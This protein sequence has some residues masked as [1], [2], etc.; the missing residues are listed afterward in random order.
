MA[1]MACKPE[2]CL[3]SHA[4]A[5]GFVSESS[6]L[7]INLKCSTFFFFLFPYYAS[8]HSLLKIT[9]MPEM[10]KMT[11]SWNADISDFCNRNWEAQHKA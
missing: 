3:S 11:T 4:L 8:W 5:F 1:N 10:A 6:N 7:R 2:N 9:D